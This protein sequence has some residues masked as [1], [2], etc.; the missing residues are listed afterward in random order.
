MFC[1][2]FS[3]GQVCCA[4]LSVLFLFSFPFRFLSFSFMFFSFPFLSSP[5][6]LLSFYFLFFSFLL[7]FFSFLF[8]S[9]SFPLRMSIRKISP[10][11]GRQT[12]FT[13][14]TPLVITFLLLVEYPLCRMIFHKLLF[15]KGCFKG[16][17]SKNFWKTLKSR[18][19]K[20]S[21]KRTES[22]LYQDSLDESMKKGKRKRNT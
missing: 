6:R 9:F 22:F 2:G 8:H 20:G 15:T 4:F 5:F 16:K 14:G 11:K 7:P 12:L 19:M 17:S 10:P 3:I 18:V 13:T 21:R 1:I